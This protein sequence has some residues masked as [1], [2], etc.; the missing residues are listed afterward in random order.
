MNVEIEN[1]AVQFQ[2]WEY[3]NQIFFAVCGLGKSQH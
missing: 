3:I 1:K 2:F